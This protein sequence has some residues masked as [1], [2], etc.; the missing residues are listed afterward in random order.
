MFLKISLK[1][2]LEYFL[3]YLKIIEVSINSSSDEVT[4][5]KQFFKYISIVKLKRLHKKLIYFLS[6][7]QQ[8]ELVLT[9]RTCMKFLCNN[10][11]S[12]TRVCRSSKW[13]NVR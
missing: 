2:S 10:K 9:K 11:T 5:E 12:F 4:D 3:L 8:F 1:P 13:A 6:N 7:F